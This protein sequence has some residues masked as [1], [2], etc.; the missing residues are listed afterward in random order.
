MRVGTPVPP[1]AQTRGG[2]TSSSA[3]LGTKQ[4]P[5]CLFFFNACISVAP[6]AKEGVIASLRVSFFFFPGLG[7]C[8]VCLLVCC[9]K[10]DYC[11]G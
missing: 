5:S 7:L 6:F 8:S 2:R 10:P 9:L 4:R 11:S 3:M 1:N